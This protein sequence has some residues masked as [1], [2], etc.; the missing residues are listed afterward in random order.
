M[1]IKG[2]QPGGLPIKQPT[3]CELVS[4]RKT[5]KTLGLTVPPPFSP[6]PTR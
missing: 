6:T 1:S 2:E 3:K 4:K 5:A